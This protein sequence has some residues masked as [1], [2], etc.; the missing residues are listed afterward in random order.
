MYVVGGSNPEAPDIKQL[1]DDGARLDTKKRYWCRFDCRQCCALVGITQCSPCARGVKGISTGLAH[2]SFSLQQES[3]VRLQWVVLPLS[4]V[5]SAP[6]DYDCTCSTREGQCQRQ[7]VRPRDGR[8]KA[9]STGITAKPS[10]SPRFTVSVFRFR[11][12]RTPTSFYI[13]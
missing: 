1:V 10:F 4:G 13:H 7:P 2:Q 5:R 6:Y 3:S 9:V 11:C 12:E 8:G